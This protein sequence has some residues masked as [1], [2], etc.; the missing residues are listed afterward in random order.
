VICTPTRGRRLRAT[1]WMWRFRTTTETTDAAT[2][3]SRVERR[4]VI[5]PR[6]FPIAFTSYR[7]SERIYLH[8]LWE[9]TLA[10]N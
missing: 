1:I 9:L 3:A 2:R 6:T 8:M 5:S 4:Y 10:V 7:W